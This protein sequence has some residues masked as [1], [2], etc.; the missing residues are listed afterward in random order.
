MAQKL[1]NERAL[2]ARP[3]QQRGNHCRRDMLPQT[4]QALLL[5]DRGCNA[6]E[7]GPLLRSLR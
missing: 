5:C 1:H 6:R 2:K 4:P 7:E 3:Q